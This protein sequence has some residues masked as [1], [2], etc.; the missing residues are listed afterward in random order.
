MQKSIL[1]VDD[2]SMIVD[3][4]KEFLAELPIDIDTASDGIT[5]LK[6][7]TAKHYDLVL[8]D[9]LLPGMSG[10]DVL[11]EITD[12]KLKMP[13]I[14]VCSG[15]TEHDIISDAIQ[16]GAGDYFTKPISRVE[17]LTAIAS[18]LD[19]T[20]QSLP[21]AAS[22]KSLLQIN[23]QM[24]LQKRSGTVRITTPQGQGQL[25]YQHGKLGTIIL[26]DLKG[27]EAMEQLKRLRILN[28]HIEFAQ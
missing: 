7:I 21:P 14:I 5:G 9:L 13:Y 1:I 23:A 11:L 20:S 10:L 19:L 22:D 24:V 15:L 3:I 16:A 4:Y 17:F 27:I 8:L 2:E 28:V 25:T 18:L 6:L 26:R 12:R